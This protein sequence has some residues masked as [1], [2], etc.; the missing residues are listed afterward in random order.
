MGD[1]IY[2][3][4][5]EY[6]AMGSPKNYGTYAE[7]NPGDERQ[8]RQQESGTEIMYMGVCGVVVLLVIALAVLSSGGFDHRGDFGAQA[9]NSAMVPIQ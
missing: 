4:P 6:R 3:S 7:N 8:T 5:E 1:K 2:V 9:V